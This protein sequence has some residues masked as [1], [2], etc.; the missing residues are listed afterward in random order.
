MLSCVGSWQHKFLVRRSE[1]VPSGV[2]IS[3]GT[4]SHPEGATAT[5][6][7]Y[8]DL[9]LVRGPMRWIFLGSVAVV[10]M[11]NG[12]GREGHA[13]G[14]T[15]PQAQGRSTR[16]IPM[17]GSLAVGLDKRRHGPGWGRRGGECGRTRA[18]DTSTLCPG[19]AIWTVSRCLA[20]MAPSPP[21]RR[22]SCIEI[23]ATPSLSAY[24]HLRSQSQHSV[25]ACAQFTTSEST[26]A[27][28]NS[29]L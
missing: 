4:S 19:S 25:E 2:W 14:V 15:D 23:S 13:T 18:R 26:R 28:V 20:A 8:L 22:P 9:V 10:G 12:Y 11:G 29:R 7:C 24:T 17:S 5:A 6:S 3:G 16:S 1:W 21:R 27:S